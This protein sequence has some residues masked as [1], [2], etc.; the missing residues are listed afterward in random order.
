MW[1]LCILV[2]GFTLGWKF[3]ETYAK[4]RIKKLQSDIENSIE[5]IE[6]IVEDIMPIYIEKYDGS[7]FAY[8]NETHL[9]LAKANN[10]KELENA[11]KLRFPDKKFACS[12]SNM[13]EVGFS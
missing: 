13:N 4:V 1:S 6:N 7:F 3:R 2:L 12:D 5:K 11:L 8:D 10:K 9:F